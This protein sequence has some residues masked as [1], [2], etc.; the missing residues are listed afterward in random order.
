VARLARA[1]RLAGQVVVLKLRH[2]DFR[3]ITRRR[4][5]PAAIQTSKALFREARLMLKGEIGDVAYRLIG[6]GLA[7]LSD[8]EH[9]PD[10]L[11][12]DGELRARQSE[13]LVDGLR[14][15]FGAQAVVNARQLR[16]R[17]HAADLK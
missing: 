1:E 10:D 4:T 15:R 11:F 8:A 14:D 17:T 5:Q 6:V 2:A 13:K 7:N 3:I 12:P 9:G 16:R